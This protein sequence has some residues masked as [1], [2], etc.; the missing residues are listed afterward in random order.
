MK[1]IPLSS[2]LYA[3]ID[4]DLWAELSQYR[5]Q[6]GNTSK[7]GN[8]PRWYA[9]RKEGGVTVYLHRAVA[10]PPAGLVVDHIDGDTLDNRRSNLRVVTHR[11]NCNNRRK[12]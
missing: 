2:G 10:C 12:R 1:K 8:D 3:L 4:N 6:A 5:W 11:E 9:M 7:P